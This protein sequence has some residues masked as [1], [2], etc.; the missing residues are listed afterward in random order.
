[1]ATRTLSRS[2]GHRRAVVSDSGAKRSIRRSVVAA[3]AATDAGDPMHDLLRARLDTV[4]GTDTADA[5][6]STLVAVSRRRSPIEAGALLDY[7]FRQLRG[8][9]GSVVARRKLWIW[10]RHCAARPEVEAR[11]MACALLDAFWK[12]HRKDVERLL[13]N[14]ARDEDREVRLY[15]ASTMARVI[16]SSFKT[17]VRHLRAWSRH[18]DPSVRRQVIIATVAVADERHPDWAKALLDLLEPHLSD[19]DPYIR[20]NLGPFALGQGMLRVYPDAALERFA[21]WLGSN[22]EIVRWNIAMAFTGPVAALRCEKALEILKVLASDPRRFVWGAA[23]HAL[24]N[25]V[26]LR[27]Q[28][29]QPV[30][31][32]WMADPALRVAVSS[33][34]NP[35]VR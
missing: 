13:L 28:R 5:L 25:M 22:D 34:F 18:P 6:V 11:Q 24:K 14:L 29:V 35:S 27:P 20:R 19:R 9:L 2:S 26:Q 16:R 15:A 4:M 8:R 3:T 31:R 33:A 23:A 32:Q 12:D 7:A 17:N 30:L 1:M 10:T 21:K